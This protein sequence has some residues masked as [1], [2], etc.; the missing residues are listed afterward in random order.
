[1]SQTQRTFYTSH[2]AGWAQISRTAITGPP[3]SKLSSTMTQATHPLLDHWDRCNRDPASVCVCVCSMKELPG[4]N[5]GP[6]EG[7]IKVASF[8]PALRGASEYRTAR[9][10]QSRGRKSPNCVENDS[11]L[12]VVR[13]VDVT[14][15]GLHTNR[16]QFEHS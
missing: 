2:A 8:E 3:T 6:L 12:I 15:H 4:R 5:N 9:L 7:N 16:S 10:Q 11:N 1:M 13:T 14:G